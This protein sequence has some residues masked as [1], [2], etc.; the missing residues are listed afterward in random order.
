MDKERLIEIT[1]EIGKRVDNDDTILEMMAEIS[2]AF[3]EKPAFNETDVYDNN[4]VKWSEKYDDL[5]RR[6]RERFITGGEEVKDTQRADI[7][8][9]V[10]DR[11]STNY[12]DLF[13]DRTGDYERRF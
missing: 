6:Y 12:E 5:S 9:D 13:E 11:M 8:A 10:T 1:Q 2:N 4:G 7:I 3:D